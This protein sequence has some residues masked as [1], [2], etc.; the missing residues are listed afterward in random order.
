MSSPWIFFKWRYLRTRL[1]LE[2]LRPALFLWPLF[3]FLL[4]SAAL[5]LSYAIYQTE[6]WWI[7]WKQAGGNAF[8]YCEFNLLESIVRQPANT[9]S[10]LGY[11]LVSL[12]IFTVA[13]SD[14][15]LLPG[16]RQSENFLVRYPLFS[17][18]YALTVFYLF[19]GSFLFHASLTEWFQKLDQTAMYFLVWLVLMFNFYKMLPRITFRLRSVSTH[20]LFM[21]LFLLGC[22][23]IYRYAFAYNI[24]FLF[25]AMVLIGLSTG[26]LYLQFFNGKNWMLRYLSSSLVLLLLAA[27]IWL[28]DRHHILCDPNSFLQGHAIWHIL[29]AASILL[30]YMYYRSGTV[31]ELSASAE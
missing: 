28:L 10:N 27:G 15:R 5:S 22:F 26:I 12:L 21:G 19:L 23:L 8:Q 6:A 13:F 18:F 29:T 30:V 17:V 31:Q 7:S 9:W 14:Y 25:P 2:H 4:G 11:L 1:Y 3:L 20:P 16:R 24:N